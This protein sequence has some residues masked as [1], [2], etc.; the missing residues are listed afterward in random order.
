[1]MVFFKLFAHFVWNG[2]KHQWFYYDE[3]LYNGE[4]AVCKECGDRFK[5]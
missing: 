1:M 5:T 3:D 2:W 4:Y